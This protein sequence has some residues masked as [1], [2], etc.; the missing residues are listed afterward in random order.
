MNITIKKLSP[1]LVE[2]Y[3]HFFDCTPHSTTK[4]EHRCYC[5]CW[6]AD[7]YEGRDFSTAEKR[8]ALAAA[9]V[10]NGSLQG[11]LAYCGEQVVGW[12]NANTKANCYESLSWTMFMQAIEKEDPS[13]KV[14]SVFCFTI[15]PE[16]RG[17]GIATQLLHRVCEDAKADGFAYVEGYPSI[18]PKQMEDD[19]AGTVGMF[20]K[21]GFAQAYPFG[22]KMV[23]R[24]AL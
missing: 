2:D 1:A 23:M 17:K 3:L 14:K 4:A 21:A 8:R 24:K 18:E 5:V 22:N 10:Q 20:T 16:M 12:C 7:P 19:F 6:A 11:Y 9:Y 13:K 15:A